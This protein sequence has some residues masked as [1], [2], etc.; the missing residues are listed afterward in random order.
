[1][2][3]SLYGLLAAAPDGLSQAELARRALRLVGTGGEGVIEAVG[4]EVRRLLESDPRFRLEPP[5]RWRLAVAPVPGGG[6]F[7]PPGETPLD[8]LTFAVVDLETTG[9]RTDRDRVIEVGAVR[10]S[11]GRI[12]ER[13]Q[14]F[15]NPGRRIPPFVT[16]LTGIDDSMV[17]AAPPFGAVADRVRGFVR[18]TVVVA[19]NAAFDGR[20]LD[21]EL[22]AA[23]GRPLERPLL[24]TVRVGRRLLAGLVPRMNLDTVADYY[25]F[26][27][28]GRHRALGDA[29]VTALVLI[30]FLERCREEGIGTWVDL[31]RLTT[32]RRGA[33]TASRAKPPAGAPSP[34][35]AGAAGE[36]SGPR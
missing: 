23:D 31:R 36:T 26:G 32:R 34:P 35:A 11:G 14:S 2:L 12:V 18:D 9:C 3:P 19:H 8:A 17:E 21:A 7:D 22:A 10:V 29:E 24:C 1:M 5:D 20:F 27:F 13:F 6:A 16:R 28:E 25:G 30:R 15:V 4:V 33:R